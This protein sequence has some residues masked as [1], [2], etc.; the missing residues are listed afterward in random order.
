MGGSESKLCPL[1]ELNVGDL[2]LFRGEAV[3]QFDLLESA[4]SL[5]K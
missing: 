4:P 5:S 2:I 3:L 1:N